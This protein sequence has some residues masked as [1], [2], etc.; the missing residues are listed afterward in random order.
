[1]ITSKTNHFD[2]TGISFASTVVEV[3][4][5]VL[6]LDNRRDF[7]WF[8]ITESL[9]EAITIELFKQKVNEFFQISIHDQILTDK[10]GL[11]ASSSDLRRT[12]ACMRPV[13]HVSSWQED[14]RRGTSPI[15]F[16]S[17]NR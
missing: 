10:F 7:E 12:L 13:I 17:C 9:I 3:P 15:P 1:M 2:E 14:H 4:Y 5:L 6:V 16:P 8:K 11:I